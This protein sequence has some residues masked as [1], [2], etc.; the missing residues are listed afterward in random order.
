MQ[1]GM[2]D[3]KED[4]PFTWNNHDKQGSDLFISIKR[5]KYFYVQ[6]LCL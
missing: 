2:Y 6:V 4:P 5:L 1:F 3:M